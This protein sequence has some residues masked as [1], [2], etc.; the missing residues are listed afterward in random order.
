MTEEAKAAKKGFTWGNAF[1]VT[2]L[3]GG[4]MLV[5]T[6]VIGII[7]ILV[8][9]FLGMARQAGTIKVSSLQRLPSM[10][11]RESPRPARQ[12]ECRPAVTPQPAQTVQPVV[13]QTP[14][15]QV[16]MVQQQPAVVNIPQPMTPSYPPPE[17]YQPVYY[18]NNRPNINVGLVI[19]GG[20]IGGGYASYSNGGGYYGGDYCAPSYPQPPY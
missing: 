11:R 12:E 2:L 8:A 6:I 7:M 15:P 18:G 17:M 3:A 9:F 14:A 16:I 5:A 1:K 4:I 13:V 20:R 19:A 10:E